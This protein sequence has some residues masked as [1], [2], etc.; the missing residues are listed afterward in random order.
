MVDILQNIGST[1]CILGLCFG[2]FLFIGFGLPA[3]GYIS[4]RRN[5]RRQKRSNQQHRSRFPYR[6]VAYAMLGVTL[7]T[8]A[9]C[10]Y[11]LF[12]GT[13]D[14]SNDLGGV[15]GII[16]V[17]LLL[18]I[19]AFRSY[20]LQNMPSATE[21]VEQDPRPPVLYLRSFDQEMLKFV[22]LKDEE[23]ARYNTFLNYAGDVN[24]PPF[25][26]AI[27]TALN[28]SAL[29]TF[30]SVESEDVTFEKYFRGEVMERIGPFVA[31]GN[32]ID[33]LPTEGAFRDYQIDERWKDVFFNHSERAACI[34]MQLGSSD[35]LQYEL[36]AILSR[37]I[38]HKLFILTPPQENLKDRYAWVRKYILRE[39]PANWQAFSAILQKNGFRIP[40][41][42]LGI[43]SVLTFEKDGSPLVL[44]RNAFQPQEYIQPIAERLKELKVIE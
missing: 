23:K 19:A 31:L 9:I 33:S 35:N 44:V 42:P 4:K 21:A 40:D 3:I 30:G 8:V 14:I 16:A 34:L 22:H 1:L 17:P 27:Y 25:E 36:T 11:W 43:G 13:F 7:M 20:I 12:S 10:I 26:Q 24:L 6:L 37:H 2:P 32:P 28:S 15:A 5:A 29:L 39:K 38:S 41:E 18:T